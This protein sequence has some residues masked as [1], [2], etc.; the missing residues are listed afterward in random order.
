MDLLDKLN[1]NEKSI[2]FQYNLPPHDVDE[3]GVKHIIVDNKK[4][5]LEIDSEKIVST[6][7]FTFPISKV[8]RINVFYSYQPK[9]KYYLILFGKFI[10]VLKKTNELN[11]VERINEVSH[12]YIS[13]YYDTGRPQVVICL[14]GKEQPLVTDF[15]YEN[16]EHKVT[17]ETENRVLYGLNLTIVSQ[18]QSLNVAVK[19]KENQLQEKDCL[20][21]S[22]TSDL[23]NS[24]KTSIYM[25]SNAQ[26]CLQPLN[27]TRCEPMS[28]GVP[29]VRAYLG[30]W[31]IGFPV[32][33]LQEKPIARMHV[34][35][36]GETICVEKTIIFVPRVKTLEGSE[37][38]T[39]QSLEGHKIGVLAAVIKEP[40]ITEN[41]VNFT[42]SASFS[43][44]CDV[45][46]HQIYLG[47]I[48]V[49]ID[50]IKSNKL[51]PFHASKSFRDIL[52]YMS[53]SN[54]IQ[55]YLKD[56]DNKQLFLNNLKDNYGFMPVT[57]RYT[58]NIMEN[59]V[60][61]GVLVGVETNH[62]G[63]IVEFYTKDSRQLTLL[64]Q[65]LH[66]YHFIS[67]GF[68]TSPESNFQT[69]QTCIK[70]ELQAVQNITRGNFASTSDHQVHA[71]SS[72]TSS[73]SSSVFTDDPFKVLRKTKKSQRKRSLKG[74]VAAEQNGQ[75][76][77]L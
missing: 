72:S 26:Q 77:H 6:Y 1:I 41:V 69:M 36:C 70:E 57:N 12:F 56:A 46:L 28:V 27:R 13:D 76:H 9:F 17:L 65:C 64:L 75:Y 47:E 20:V 23:V 16:N 31:I 38:K 74:D 62:Y 67:A 30:K 10:V 61:T 25:P 32:T 60:F 71:A 2:L 49:D 37:F 35:I 63:C 66:K 29:W 24:R 51:V 48:S 45:Q 5:F 68:Q 18:L 40:V 7:N 42:C 50:D 19:N 34:F 54:R 15:A 14:I 58:V 39:A 73:S 8:E 21:S 43:I 33:N 4:N 52:T 11:F 3:D 53:V 59:S 55:L 22:L 44:G